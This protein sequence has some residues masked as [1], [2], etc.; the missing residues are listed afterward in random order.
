[1]EDNMIPKKRTV[2]SLIFMLLIFNVIAF[3]QP[4]VINK[5]YLDM[6]PGKFKHSNLLMENEAAESR[7]DS[8]KKR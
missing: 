5:P 1:M 6:T 3:A 7:R 4:L 8:K 2:L